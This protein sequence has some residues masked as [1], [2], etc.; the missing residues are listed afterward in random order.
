MKLNLANMLTLTALV[1]LLSSI[2]SAIMIWRKLADLDM[3]AVLK[4]KE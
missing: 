4:S 1:V 2:V 3:V